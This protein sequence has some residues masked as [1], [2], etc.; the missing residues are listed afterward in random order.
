[1]NIKTKQ[2][3]E[4]WAACI[5][6]LGISVLGKTEDDAKQGLAEA[7]ATYVLNEK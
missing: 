7:Y 3:G 2:F 4:L 6:E 1:M 5:P